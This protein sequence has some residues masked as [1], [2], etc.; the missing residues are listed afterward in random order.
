MQ[1]KLARDKSD[2]RHICPLQLDVITRCIELWTN[3]G[4]IVL[5]PFGG[6]G[7]TPYM[8]VK[9]NRRGLGIELKESYYNV[10]VNNLEDAVNEP[11]TQ[12]IQI[13]GQLNIFDQVS[14]L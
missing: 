2:E 8:A 11:S 12:N 9:L 14:N 3:P 5:D 7:S 6:I 13:G 1:K 10:S 4:D